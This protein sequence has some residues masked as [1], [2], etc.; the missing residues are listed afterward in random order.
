M[1]ERLFK[2]QA[3][4]TETRKSTETVASIETMLHLREQYD[5]ALIELNKTGVLQ[6]LPETGSFGIVGFDGKEY[7]MPQYEE[8]LRKVEEQKEKLLPKIEQGFTKILITPFA[9]PL[10]T[11]VERYKRLL[12]EKH[13]KGKLLA[14]KKS[15]KDSDTKLDLDTTT[16]V[17][18]WDEYK[19]A[20][21]LGK[22]IYHP[23]SFSRDHGGKTKKDLVEGGKSWDVSLVE[24]LPNLPGEGQG[25]TV[26]NRKQLESNKSS[27]DY[28][29]LT[30]IDPSH[31]N[32]SGFTPE[33]WLTL[34]ITHLE[35]TNEVLDD[36]QGN[37][38]LAFLFGSY[39]PVS[40]SVPFAY[41]SRDCR[42]AFLDRAYP[43]P[44]GSHYS[45]RVSVG[46]I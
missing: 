35:K 41:F 23:K 16:P 31:K 27:S 24:D 17:W 10:D 34:A 28:L 43:D 13:K 40:G 2:K 18:V 37:G 45:G 9:M 46:V 29:K 15:P 6:I 12:L 8:I 39:F 42:Q 21:V 20:D 26:G 19:G 11:L 5:T 3:P 38:K 4:I 22:L 7:P 32:E 36:Y 33:K 44:R 30:Q 25:K 14:T 1:L